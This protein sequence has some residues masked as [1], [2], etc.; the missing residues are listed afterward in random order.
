MNKKK[1]YETMKELDTEITKINEL[2][3]SGKKMLRGLMKD[4][5]EVLQKFDKKTNEKDTLIDN[6]SDISRQFETSHPNI[7]SFLS[8]MIDLLSN[9]GI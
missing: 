3:E 9:M 5:D 6:I 4:I 8:R 2:D 7:T 1:L